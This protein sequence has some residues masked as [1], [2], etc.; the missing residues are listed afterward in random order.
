MSGTLIF[1]LIIKE[2]N[3]LAFTWMLFMIVVTST[4]IQGATLHILK[5][6]TIERDSVI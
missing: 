4:Y 6:Y 5:G 1:F 2:S 3:H